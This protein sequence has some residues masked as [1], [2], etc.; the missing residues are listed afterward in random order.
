M[1]GFVPSGQAQALRGTQDDA[2]PPRKGKAWQSPRVKPVKSTQRKPVPPPSIRQAGDP[3]PPA[4]A[5][6]VKD[7]PPPDPVPQRRRKPQ[8]PDPWEPL[9][10]RLGGIEVY[11]W[12][13][14]SLGYDSNPNRV[15]HPGHGS[16]VVKTEVGV[17]AKSDWSVHEFE[18]KI[19]GAYFV[20]PDVSSADRPDADASLRLRL[21]ATRDLAVEFTANGSIGTQQPGTVEQPLVGTQRGLIY[22]SGASAAL[23]RSIGPATAT[24]KTAVQRFDYGDLE[25]GGVAV[26][27]DFRNY[28]DAAVSLRLGYD[29]QPGF[30]PFVE[31][32]V[33]RRTYAHTDLLAGIDADSD[34]LV[35]R[36]GV[37]VDITRVIHG[38]A[39][40]GYGERQPDDERL[41]A[42]RGPLFDASILWTPTALT[43]VKF[44]AAN[45][46][47]DITAASSAG[48]KTQSVG[49]EVTHALRRNLSLIGFVTAA[50]T[51]Y[52]GS[53][54]RETGVTTGVKLD[55][56]VNRS[57]VLR[58]SFTHERLQSSVPG[59]DYTANVFLVGLRLQR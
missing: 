50:R 55:Y 23:I 14:E 29:V 4:P 27:Q 34:G 36:A 16:G 46:L 33:D 45:S 40:V 13:E 32:Q 51:D 8:Q 41:K 19:R 17:T 47:G 59:S 28:D 25:V 58:T 15:P 6:A 22:G 31:A 48:S 7:I 39:S 38:E 26:P 43:S 44:T 1:S 9:G 49:V 20:Y 3:V 54:T 52:E 42:L 53:G 18:A 11:P 30:Q 37:S 10:L 2:P 56:K 57:L 24:L 12:F 5:P 35:G 21:D